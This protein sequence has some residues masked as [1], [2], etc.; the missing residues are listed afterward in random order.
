MSLPRSYIFNYDYFL[1]QALSGDLPELFRALV[2]VVNLELKGFPSGE[3]HRCF[4]HRIIQRILNNPVL[5]DHAI[6]K[7]FVIQVRGYG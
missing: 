6:Q 4:S 2:A 7:G 1:A 3:V 5:L